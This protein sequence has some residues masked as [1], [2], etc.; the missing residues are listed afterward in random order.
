MRILLNKTAALTLLL[1]AGGLPAFAQTQLY[2][3]IVKAEVYNGIGGSDVASL[4]NNAKF[5]NSPDVVA[6]PKFLEY[7]AGADDGTAPAANVGSNYGTRMSGVIIPKDTADYVFYV[8][9][10]D[11]SSFFSAGAY[12]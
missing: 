4:T 1:G 11:N 2:P 8:A 6:Y 10:D 7:P 12:T 5:P 9:S 3:G